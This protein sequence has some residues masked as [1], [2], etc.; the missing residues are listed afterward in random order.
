M[1]QPN[2]KRDGEKKE[3]K[4]ARKRLAWQK[5]G[6]GLVRIMARLGGLAQVLKFKKQICLQLHLANGKFIRSS[7]SIKSY[8]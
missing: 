8:K 4:N 2:T 6:R 3:A 1:K 7:P 5:M